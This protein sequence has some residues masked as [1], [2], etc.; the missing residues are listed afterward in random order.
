MVAAQPPHYSVVREHSQ[1]E[2]PR[3]H[4]DQPTHTFRSR[5]GPARRGGTVMINRLKTWLSSYWHVVTIVLVGTGLLGAGLWCAS[6]TDER[7]VLADSLIAAGSGL[8]TVSGVLLAIFEARRGHVTAVENA[9]AVAKVT[10]SLAQLAAESRNNEMLRGRELKADQERELKRLLEDELRR[11]RLLISTLRSRGPTAIET[12]A[13]ELRLDETFK[14]NPGLPRRSKDS[15][16]PLE[17]A[18]RSAGH[19]VALIGPALRERLAN[20]SSGTTDWIRTQSELAR[21]S[22]RLRQGISSLV[23][24]VDN[25]RKS[26]EKIEAGLSESRTSDSRL[27][28]LLE[29]RGIQ[30][31]LD[32]V[33]LDRI[34]RMSNITVMSAVQQGEEEAARLGI[35]VTA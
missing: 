19:A 7:V 26:I 23:S 18:Q 4:A 25:L 35:S 1:R 30:T 5:M 22:P 9:A 28:K 2:E 34:D 17:V 31:V 32:A 13:A 33:L 27:S 21:V 20:N 6:G 10:E 29:Q 24:A 16:T 8:I 11:A 14:E 12:L 3:A 15:P